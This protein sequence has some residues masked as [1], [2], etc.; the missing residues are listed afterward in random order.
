[1]SMA[2]CD[3]PAP[4]KPRKGLPRRAQKPWAE[5]WGHGHRRLWA[6]DPRGP[7]RTPPCP[8][9]ASVRVCMCVHM[10]PH[11]V[12]KAQSGWL[13]PSWG[14][15]HFPLPW[16]RGRPR[17]APALCTASSECHPPSPLPPACLPANT[18]S[19]VGGR[20]PLSPQPR[21]GVHG[22]QGA[23]CM[24]DPFVAAAPSFPCP[25]CDV[26]YF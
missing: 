9:Q 21:A 13:S 16:S 5:P 8:L 4:L 20:D 7:H 12:R 25:R 22:A 18:G 15:K 11:L 24:P 19:G 3:R 6:N 1:M 26:Y 17:L 14:P 23:R 10:H 2:A